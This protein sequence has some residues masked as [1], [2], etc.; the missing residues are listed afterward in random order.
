MNFPSIRCINSYTQRN[1]KGYWALLERLLNKKIPLIPP[2]SYRQYVTDF[3]KIAEL[4]NSFFPK[5]CSLVSNSK[6]LHIKLHY[7]I[8][9]RLNTP[10]VSNNAIEKIIQNVDTIEI[11]ICTDVSFTSSEA[12]WTLIRKLTNTEVK[13]QTALSSLR[14]SYKRALNS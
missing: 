7:T 10:N 14:V 1:S 9:K 12:M 6:K 3:K 13:S 5:Q 11:E 2:L 4:L 8:E